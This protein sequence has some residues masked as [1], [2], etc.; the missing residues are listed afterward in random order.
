MNWYIAAV[1]KYAVFN[2]RAR[3]KEYWYF[4]LFNILVSIALT[5]IDALTGSLN[6]EGIGLL[7]GIY[8]LAMFI[9]SIAVGVRRLHD[10]GRSGWWILIV[11]V[12]LI[13]IIALIIFFALDSTPEDNKYGSNPKLQ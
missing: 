6:A 13:G 9:P 3:R 5:L 8:S 10:T 7:S 12:P 11:L 1:K 2:E 4:V